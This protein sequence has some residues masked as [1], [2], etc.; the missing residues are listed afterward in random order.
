MSTPDPPRPLSPPTP[1]RG[2]VP[3]GSSTSPRRPWWQRG[4][5]AAIIGAGGLAVGAGVG[6]ALA[7]GEDTKTV[8][9]AGPTTIVHAS[10]TTTAHAAAPNSV[11]SAA[12]PVRTVSHTV[13]QTVT[14]TVA[15]SL[16]PATTITAAKSY[17]G[18]GRKKIGT[19]V[20]P[21]MT[22]IVWHSSSGH[23]VLENPPSANGRRLEVNEKGT[24]GNS[25]LEEGTYQE[26]E[27]LSSGEWSFS[28]AAQ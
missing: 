12:T 21:H 20:L 10:P 7:G 5:G 16:G 19:L 1:P 26:L 24:S 8:R 6:V 9:V 15:S 14:T 17:S 25:L 4:W 23:F 28:L 18:N 13:T 11:H 27:V 2:S 3:D 22:A